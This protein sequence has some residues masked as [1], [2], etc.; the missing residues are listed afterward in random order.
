MTHTA[1]CT[2]VGGVICSPIPG[3]FH[4]LTKP[5]VVL[6]CPGLALGPPEPRSPLCAPSSAALEATLPRGGFSSVVFSPV[7]SGL[8]NCSSFLGI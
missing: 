3:V 6:Q 5:A 8:E 7:V 4:L 2:G 1:P